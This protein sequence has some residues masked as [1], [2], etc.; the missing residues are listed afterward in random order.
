M[1]LA[2]LLCL[3]LSHQGLGQINWTKSLQNPIIP[4]WNGNIDDPNALK[5]AIEP[6]VI[7]NEGTGIH[8][9]WFSS[10]TH[11]F[12]T[13]LSVSTA[14]SLDGLSWF[15]YLRNPILAKGPSGSFDQLGIFGGEVIHSG[16]QYMM[17]YSGYDGGRIRIGLATSTDG[18]HWQK[19]PTNPV[20]DVGPSGTWDSQGVVYP[21]VLF[22]GT[23]YWMWYNGRSG[24]GWGA[25]GFA[26]SAD[27]INWVKYPANPVLSPGS[28][29]DSF[30]TVPAGIVK[31]NNVF[32]L[33]YLGAASSAYRSQVGLATSPDG[34][35]WTKYSAD[36]V[37]QLGLPGSWDDD[38]FGG[39]TL[40]FSNDQFFFWYSARNYATEYWQCG[41]A[42]S[43][44]EPLSVPGQGN[45][46]VTEFR[47]EQCYPN[48][49]NPSTVLTFSVP[50]ESHVEIAVFNTVGQRVATLVDGR[51]KP[52]VHS[53]TFDS[54]NLASGTYWYRMTAENFAQT[55][56]MV[57][58]K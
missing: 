30:Y 35:T 57:L 54:A 44:L 26:T 13:S 36:P 42:T 10:L 21:R 58:V 41:L 28:G 50:R 38:S 17:Y 47:L 29:W 27:G 14:V 34:V 15:A 5:Y 20:L 25:T 23:M 31:V 11:G 37:L 46:V 56:S 1:R 48:P 2:I 24:S 19:H 6:S 53:V 39:G 7:V 49:F 9:M 8:K 33:L 55:R 52:G 43:P 12:G 18:I 40:G 4:F 51:L 22:D 45:P 16:S 3:L 32:Y